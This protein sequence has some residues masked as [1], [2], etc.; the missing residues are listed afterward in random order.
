MK[1][2]KRNIELQSRL[3]K[4]TTEKFPLKKLESLTVEVLENFDRGKEVPEK[5]I[6]VK[7]Y[8]I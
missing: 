1:T 7:S 5:K 2:E 3:K 8:A 6:N 4:S